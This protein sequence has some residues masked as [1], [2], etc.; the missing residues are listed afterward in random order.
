MG[1]V[2]PMEGVRGMKSPWMKSPRVRG[3]Y[4]PPYTVG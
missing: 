2:S 1:D 3:N 4:V